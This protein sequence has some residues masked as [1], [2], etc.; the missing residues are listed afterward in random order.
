[1]QERER[2]GERD[3]TM[4]TNSG[5]AASTAL[6]AAALDAAIQQVR[7]GATAIE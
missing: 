6:A 3:K 4:G 1:V 7:L 2:A 5:A